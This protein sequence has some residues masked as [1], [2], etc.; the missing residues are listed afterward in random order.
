MSPKV[1]MSS[2]GRGTIIRMIDTAKVSGRRELHFNSIDEALAEIDR[3]AALDRAGQLECV[4]NW[5]CGQ[6]CNHLATWAE[7]AFKPN[8]HKPPFFIKWILRRMK[9]R[10]IKGPMHVGVKIPKMKDG[11]LGAEPC[12]L[13]AGLARMKVIFERLKREPPTETHAIFGPLTHDESI[14]M[15]LRHAE[16]HLSFLKP[17]SS[18]ETMS[19]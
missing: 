10:F 7:F 18:I 14:A 5:T 9:H 19:S 1:H 17:R 11:T 3:L 8:P 4:G 15:N 2:S 6:V 12:S 16:L 13:E